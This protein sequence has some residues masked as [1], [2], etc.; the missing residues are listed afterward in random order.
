MWIFFFVL[1]VNE[2]IEFIAIRRKQIL[3]LYIRMLIICVNMLLI[4]LI[5]FGAI[6]SLGTV[7]KFLF[8]T[9]IIIDIFLVLNKKLL[10]KIHQVYQGENDHD[11]NS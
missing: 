10:M 4:F 7:L 9:F 11:K 3:N 2:I 8:T 1:V 6:D 5:I